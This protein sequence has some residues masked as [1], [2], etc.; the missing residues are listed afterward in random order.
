M[1]VGCRTVH[2]DDLA[3][4]ILKRKRIDHKPAIFS[5]VAAN[6]VFLLQRYALF[7]GFTVTTIGGGAIVGMN[8]VYPAPTDRLLKGLP[9]ILHPAL[10]VPVGRAVRFAVPEQIGD[11]VGD[12]LQPFFRFAQGDLGLSLLNQI[13]RLTGE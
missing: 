9:C 12:S 2:L 7:D 4:L 6:A 13:S 3:A 1:N 8:R 10:V 11:E 5:I